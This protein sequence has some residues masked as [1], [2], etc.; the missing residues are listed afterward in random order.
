MSNQLKINLF[1]LLF[2]ALP[3]ISFG[4]ALK[5]CKVSMQNDT[6]TL[7][8]KRIK[9]TFL[10]NQGDLKT[11]SIEDRVRNNVWIFHHDVP[12]LMLHERIQPEGPGS[13][14]VNTITRDKIQHDHLEVSVITSFPNILIKRVFRL[15]PECPAIACDIYVSNNATGVDEFANTEGLPVF[16]TISPEGIHWKIRTVKF[17]DQT[18]IF[19]NLVFKKDILAYFR[20]KEHVGNILFLENKLTKSGFFILKEAASMQS[21]SNYPGA[22][23]IIQQQDINNLLVKTVGL[24][25][26]MRQLPR[27]EWIRCNGFVTG[28]TGSSGLDKLAALRDYQEQIRI[29]KPGRDEMIL[30]NTWG[31]RGQDARIN[32]PFTLQELKIGKR[33]G[34]THF[35]LDDGWQSGRSKN[36]AFEG[37]SLENIWN[38][39]SFWLVH[40]ERFPNGLDPIVSKAEEF[41]IKIGL[42]FNPSADN[43][44]KN[45]KKDAEVL[46]HYY[47]KYNIRTFKIDGVELPDKLAEINFRK[48]MDTVMMATDSNAVINLDVT[49]AAK[50]PGYHFFNE[51]GNIFLENRYTDWGNYYPHWTLRN[52]W[53]LSEYVPPQNLQIEFLNKW[54]N[55]DKYLA[56][57]PLAPINLPFDYLFATTIAGQPLAWFEGSNLPEEAFE[58]APLVKKYSNVMH[59]IHSGQIFPIGEEPSGFGWTGFQSVIDETSGY[60]IVYREFNVNDKQSLQTWL[61]SN[62]TVHFKKILGDGENFSPQTGKN[63]E[64]EF[65][66]PEKWSFAVYQYQLPQ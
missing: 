1:I 62:T 6:L 36:S 65:T 23:F 61:P 32:E 16:E 51:Y 50:R 66:L 34:I 28:V 4:Q 64:V 37:G 42:W 41:G 10:W 31:D 52:L 53:M 54:R 58:I 35:Q 9:R 8:N 12:D 63:G 15:Y 56:D 43:S 40:P 11:L 38:R 57:D 24:G 21:Q 19:N 18:D 39:D 44:Y 25:V 30:M 29:H 59:D 2:F 48:L 27:E 46:I 14:E 13:Y 22:D 5:D 49:G 17:L 20:P 33:L 47:G 7:S 60:I 26:D 3:V 45:W 55:P